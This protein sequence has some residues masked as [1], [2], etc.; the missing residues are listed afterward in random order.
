M[1]EVTASPHDVL[2]RTVATLDADA[3]MAVVDSLQ[4]HGAKVSAVVAVPL[5]NLQ[6]KRDV[7]A[8]A[9]GAPIDAVAGLL[10]L[11]AMDPLEKVIEALG[12]HSETPTYEQLSAAVAS[13]RGDALS[14][15]EV[16]AVLGF[17]IGNEFPAAPHCRRLLG[18]DDALALAEIEITIGHASLLS[19]KVVDESVREQ[20]RARREQEKARKQAR[21]AKA[22]PATPA[23]AKPDKKKPAPVAPPAPTAPAVLEVTRRALTLTPAEAALYDPAHPL[24]GAVV[25]TE[26]PFDAVDP[27]IPE[28]QSKIRPAVVLAG[29]D[30]G[31]L[32][33]GIY[34]NPSPSRQ[35]FTAWRR[36]GLDHVSYVDDARISVAADATAARLGVLTDE[37]WNSLF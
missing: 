28:Q 19:P 37:E 1:T 23:R 36:L 18:E 35:L 30:Q 6:K 10:E 4:L 21:A 12:E 32:V 26:V 3:V 2:R 8:F 20:R 24:A 16:I 9:A 11:L 14:D 22:K 29:S 33:R 5:R 15:D 17:A 13:L 34:S 27:V 7:A 25:T 31:L